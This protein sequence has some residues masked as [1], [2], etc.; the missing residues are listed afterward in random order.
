MATGLHCA[1]ADGSIVGYPRPVVALAGRGRRFI[2]SS[3]RLLDVACRTIPIAGVSLLVG[4]AVWDVDWARLQPALWITIGSGLGLLLLE[5]VVD[6]SWLCQGRGLAAALKLGPLGLIPVAPEHRGSLLLA[7]RVIA[8]VGSHMPRWFR[9]AVLVDE[10]KRLA[11]GT[12]H[13]ERRT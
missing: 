10:L 2:V 11:G 4:G 12:F 1:T 5:V 9:H 13:A 7:V 8:S 6:Q 3:L